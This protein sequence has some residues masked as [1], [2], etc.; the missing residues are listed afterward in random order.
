MSVS[1]REGNPDIRINWRLA[2]ALVVFAYC[3]FM[4]P[5]LPAFRIIVG[6]EPVYLDPAINLAEGTGLRS[7]AWWQ[8]PS[9]TWAG[10]VPLHALVSAGWISLGA[11]EGYVANRLM[12]FAFFVVA[13]WIFAETFARTLSGMRS[14]QP[15]LFAMLL[16]LSLYGSAISQG[17][18]PDALAML[19]LAGWVFF[20]SSD[21]PLVRVLSSF[22]AG[23]LCILTGF[24]VA[25][26]L[27]IYFA[28]IAF[29]DINFFRRAGE[30][31]AAGAGF[32]AAL[33]LL[34]WFYSRCGVWD[35][36]WNS[37]FGMQANRFEQWQGLRDPVLWATTLVCLAGLFQGG[38]TARIARAGL[39]GGIGLALIFFAIMKFPQYYA[40]FALVPSCAV[41]AAILPRLKPAPMKWSLGILL[42]SSCAISFP[43]VCIMTWNNWEARSYSRVETWA[44]QTVRPNDVAFVN[45]SAYF[46]VRPLAADIFTN[47]TLKTLSTEERRKINLVIIW[48]DREGPNTS[49]G[50]IMKYL[51]GDWQLV[52]SYEATEG[53]SARWAKLAF[54]NRLSA[55]SPYRFT[56][57]RRSEYPS[58]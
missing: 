58:R 52:S 3:A 36:F 44:Q 32:L 39:T 35:V 49:Y 22:I 15:A 4:I 2:F 37:T 5:Q 31:A 57:Y 42:G 8:H 19:I 43:L 55:V 45:P 9:E 41:A 26:A 46:A 11:G 25:L 34:Y 23:F 7:S 18:R 47:A 20:Q 54:L 48:T 17:I 33:V 29:L 27:M 10:N 28:A 21:R 1:V 53:L 51:P 24:Q 30:A 38:A 14:W 12:S 40:F 13:L 56:A 50:E 6:D 16:L